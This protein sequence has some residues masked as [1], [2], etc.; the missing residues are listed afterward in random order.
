MVYSV[1]IERVWGLAQRLGKQGSRVPS[2]A[3]AHGKP[4]ISVRPVDVREAVTRFEHVLAILGI[5]WLI[6]VSYGVWATVH[7]GGG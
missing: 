5:I 3:A 1:L 7:R 4:A 2:T 6:G